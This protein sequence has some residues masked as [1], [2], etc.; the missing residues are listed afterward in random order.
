[1]TW[2]KYP[3]SIVVM[4]AI[5][6]VNTVRKKVPLRGLFKSIAQERYVLGLNDC[7]NKSAKYFHAVK[8]IGY[9]P[10]IIV[11]REDNGVLHAVVNVDGTY[12]DCTKGKA[13]LVRPSNITLELK[14]EDFGK[15]N[16][17]IIMMI[18]AVIKL[19]KGTILTTPATMIN[20]IDEEEPITKG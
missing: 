17:E 1:M 10:T 20:F 15:F 7:S 14:E 18:L 13:S 2:I 6:C 5:G 9:D 8:A 4:L 16:S 11:Y 3:I 19:D 12:I